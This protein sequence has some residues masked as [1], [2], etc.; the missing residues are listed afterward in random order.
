MSRFVTVTAHDFPGTYDGAIRAEVTVDTPDGSMTTEVSATLV[1][2]DVLD[3]VDINPRVATLARG[4]LVQFRAVAYDQNG[5][6]LP[7][8][9]F[10]W[11]LMSRTV[12]SMDRNGLLTAEGDPGELSRSGTG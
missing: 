6:L 3:R 1:I 5:V 12:G 8:V 2:R 10:N 4:D 11:K 7:D 9:T